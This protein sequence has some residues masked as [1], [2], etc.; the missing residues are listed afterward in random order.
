M[1]VPIPTEQ[2][3]RKYDTAEWRESVEVCKW[4]ICGTFVQRR[5]ICVFITERIS[6][7]KHRPHYTETNRIEYSAV[8]AY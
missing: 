8:G 7:K 6:R 2:T 1:L 4:C 5:K 3:E